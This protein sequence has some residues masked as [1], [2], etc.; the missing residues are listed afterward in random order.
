M[1]ATDVAAGITHIIHSDHEYTLRKL[2][3]RSLF[4]FQIAYKLCRRYTILKLGM[5]FGMQF[6]NWQN[7]QRNFEI[8]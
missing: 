1:Q 7:A 3:T 8:V 5:Q 6:G 4:Y 2:W